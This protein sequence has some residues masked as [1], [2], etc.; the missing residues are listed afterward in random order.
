MGSSSDG[1]SSCCGYR[2]SQLAFLFALDLAAAAL[3]YYATTISYATFHVSIGKATLTLNSTYKILGI[4]GGPIAGKINSARVQL[5]QVH[6]A[7][8]GAILLGTTL[9]TFTH[10]IEYHRRKDTDDDALF[11]DSCCG[12]FSRFIYFICWLFGFGVALIGATVWICDYRDMS[13]Q[14]V[15]FDVKDG[16]KVA[17]G[18]AI[19]LL[20]S[21]LWRLTAKLS[22][23]NRRPPQ[24]GPRVYNV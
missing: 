1:R 24:S 7:G 10:I 11:Q 12:Q 18:A 5:L 13:I 3:L 4:S 20:F 2:R 9:Y 22:R 15:S 21:G 6:Q 14:V 16:A 8:I 19:A 23:P 17:T